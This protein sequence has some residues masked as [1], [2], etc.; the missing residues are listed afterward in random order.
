[1]TDDPA[2]KAGTEGECLLP[3]FTGGARRGA[4]TDVR[5]LS[6]QLVRPEEPDSEELTL[7]G[8]ELADMRGRILREVERHEAS[9]L[10]AGGRDEAVPFDLDEIRT[11][12][13]SRLDRIRDARRA[14]GVP[15]EPDP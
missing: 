9:A 4:Q 2:D 12:I 14:G 1:M 10:D 13:G 11:S 7:S 15:G 6:G 3:L 8:A 5:H